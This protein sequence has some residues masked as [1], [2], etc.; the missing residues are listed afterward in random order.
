MRQYQAADTVE[1][2]GSQSASA[3]IQLTKLQAFVHTAQSTSSE[4]AHRLQ[5]MFAHCISALHQ[6]ETR[7]LAG[8][9]PA[10]EPAPQLQLTTSTPRDGVIPPSLALLEELQA[11]RM[12]LERSTFSI[13]RQTLKLN[14]ATQKLKDTEATL[15]A[16][17]SALEES[18]KKRA[19][20][21]SNL[22]ALTLMVQQLTAEGAAYKKASQAPLSLNTAVPV[23]PLKAHQ[24]PA[25]SGI[26]PVI[27]V[28]A[29]GCDSC[30]RC[31]QPR[32]SMTRH[33]PN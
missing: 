4:N 9:L 31:A 17:A 23:V 22:D 10:A 24:A 14:A 33:S 5:G 11:V 12:K 8:F 26:S 2:L 21:E 3:D 30:P 7:A 6:L 20:V 18:E 15:H 25:G 1:F 32:H 16:K 28:C 27:H 19:A 13:E 29:C